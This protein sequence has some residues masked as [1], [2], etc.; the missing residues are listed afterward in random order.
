MMPELKVF[1]VVGFFNAKTGPLA[2]EDHYTLTIRRD[3]EPSQ[4]QQ[5]IF[6]LS[7][8]SIFTLIF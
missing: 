4:Y 7:K 2:K 1:F 8:S 3:H 6:Q 5:S